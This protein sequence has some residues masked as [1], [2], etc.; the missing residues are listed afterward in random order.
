MTAVTMGHSN[1]RAETRGGRYAGPGVDY[2]A[3]QT[4]PRDRPFPVELG[5][6]LGV[7]Q[8]GP[9]AVTCGGGPP[10][11]KDVRSGSNAI[12]SDGTPYSSW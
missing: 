12:S 5:L 2:L 3:G 8:Y 4:L 7:R 1:C 10:G 9:G 6:G 11:I